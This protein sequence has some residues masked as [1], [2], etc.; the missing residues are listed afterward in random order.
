MKIITGHTGEPHVYAVDDAA[1]NKLLVG[2]GDFVLPYGNKLA[3][4]KTD[5]HTIV[6]SD[7]YMITQG[8]LGTV[9]VGEEETFN[10]NGG[11]DG[12]NMAYFIVVEYSI[13][14]SGIESMT[15]KPIAGAKT[16]SSTPS[17]P[18]ITTGDID[19]GETH[20]VPLWRVILTGTTITKMER[21]T[22]LLEVNPIDELYGD[23]NNM[24][25]DVQ[26]AI[27]NMN[28]EVETSITEI[29]TA[30]KTAIN[31]WRPFYHVKGDTFNLKEYMCLG[32]QLT[33]SS[34]EI[35][36]VVPTKP[37]VTG[38][39]VSVVNL[40]GDMR[41]S[42]GGYPF[43]KNGNSYHQLSWSNAGT[44]PIVANGQ[45]KIAGVNSVK[46]WIVDGGILVQI[47][48][49]EPLRQPN[50]TSIAINNT[51]CALYLRTDTSFTIS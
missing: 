11:T 46:A 29:Q 18:T 41:I 7:G 5:A 50:K 20:Q 49:K 9:R 32:G 12:Y 48:L 42:T 47:M 1:V 38:T 19:N 44:Y 24:K 8:R 36:F 10:L 3:A 16:T 14:Q 45:I 34:T 39:T 43:V 13:S 22:T 30:S 26:D 21:A 27:D 51:P 6:I 31:N 23:L 17:D 28:A 40:Y 35:D 25:S 4:T 33:T 2:D 15:L 37:I